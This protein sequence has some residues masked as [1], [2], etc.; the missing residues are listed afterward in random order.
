[1]PLETEHVAQAERNERLY[2]TLCSHS[3]DELTEWEVVALF[4]SALHYVDAYFAKSNEH[5]RG[6][7]ERNQKVAQTK[8]F[9]SFA[10]SYIHLY[11]NSRDARYGQ[12]QYMV[13][14]PP[15][16]I[17]NLRDDHYELIKSEVCNLLGIIGV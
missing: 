1:M 11:H 15:Q 3:A 6:H 14:Y 7:R 16:Q 17:R 10:S 13:R 2:E 8:E 12:G 4:Y 9:S 5:P